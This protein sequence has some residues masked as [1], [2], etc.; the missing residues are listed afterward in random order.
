MSNEVYYVYGYSDLQSCD[1]Y[2]YIGKGKDSRSQD[3][4]RDCYKKN[5]A[6]YKKLQSM[7]DYGTLPVIEILINNL[8]EEDAFAYEM[9]YIRQYGRRDNGTG[10]LLNLTDGGDGTS[11]RRCTEVTIIKMRQSP[12][13]GQFK[14]GCPQSKEILIKRDKAKLEAFERLFCRHCLMSGK[15]YRIYKH[16][17]DV[18]KEGF[19]SCHVCNVLKG[20]RRQSNGYGWRYL[21]DEE[22]FEY[23]NRK[24]Y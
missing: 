8:S 9:Y 23:Y 16:I 18:V 13:S 10:C 15:I 4:L 12:N 19:S 2:F 6:F 21:T 11:G 14:V 20:R 24:E 17:S 3:H 5:T 22:K 1:P 7:L